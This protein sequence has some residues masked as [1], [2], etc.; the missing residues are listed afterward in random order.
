L[1]GLKEN[2]IVGKKIPAGTGLKKYES[3]R[4]LP[5]GYIEPEVLEESEMY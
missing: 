1:N 4:V 2:V 5:K 3:I